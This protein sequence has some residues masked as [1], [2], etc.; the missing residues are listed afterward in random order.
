MFKINDSPETSLPGVVPFDIIE[1]II[2]SFAMAASQFSAIVILVKIK[3]KEKEKCG[4]I[5]SIYS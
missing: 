2:E 3:D 1:F 5:L 4:E